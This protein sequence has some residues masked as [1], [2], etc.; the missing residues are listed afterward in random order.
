MPPEEAAAKLEVIA[1]KNPN[2]ASRIKKEILYEELGVSQEDRALMNLNVIDG[3]RAAAIHKRA[4]KLP[5]EEREAY[6]D[7][8]KEARIIT[9][10]VEE[11]LKK[12]K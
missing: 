6:L 7:L 1:D 2:L 12:L 8:L 11:Q 5:A 9:K 10:S 4:K 3:Q